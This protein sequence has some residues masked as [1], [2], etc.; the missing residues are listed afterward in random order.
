MSN[1]NQLSNTVLTLINTRE[2]A[3]REIGTIVA[4]AKRLEEALC[5]D[6]NEVCPAYDIAPLKEYEPL[7]AQ[8]DAE[9]WR[10]VFSE[11]NLYQAMDSGE[12]KRLNTWLYGGRPPHFT[13]ANVVAV[14]GYFDVG[15]ESRID[16]QA[17]VKVFVKLMRGESSVPAHPFAV[18]SRFKVPGVIRSQGTK[19]ISLDERELINNMDK[20]IKKITGKAYVENELVESVNRAVQDG[21]TFSSDLYSISVGNNGTLIVELKDRQLVK[22]LNQMV[23]EWYRNNRMINFSGMISQAISEGA[24]A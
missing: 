23:T 12:I 14:M 7:R 11:Y 16:D 24:V 9:M 5:L 8:I 4:A 2:K 1:Q 17:L 18:K 10:K 15:S 13:A 20:A 3:I 6:G 19:R 21:G 22:W